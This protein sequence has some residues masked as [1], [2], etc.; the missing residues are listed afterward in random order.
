MVHFGGYKVGQTLRQK[1]KIVNKSGSSQR[2]HLLMPDT[3]AFSAKV[4]KRGIV[5]PGMSE[6][7][8]ISFVPEEWKYYYDSI[9]I[10]CDAGNLVVPIHA[11][12]T[13]NEVKFPRILGTYLL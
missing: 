10:H 13:V 7:V 6:V 9:R 4:V 12:P 3:G 1:V 5:A 11:Y 8:T 2:M